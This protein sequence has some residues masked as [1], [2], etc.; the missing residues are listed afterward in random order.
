MG[1]IVRQGTCLLATFI[2]LWC[3]VL[4][5]KGLK[6]YKKLIMMGSARV[7]IYFLFFCSWYDGRKIISR[8]ECFFHVHKAPHKK[9]WWLSSR[10]FDKNWVI[11]IPISMRFIDFTIHHIDLLQLAKQT[12]GHSFLSRRNFENFSPDPEL[13]FKYKRD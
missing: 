11:S 4:L 1:A 6:N 3:L 7:N 10:N 13:T 2:L 5:G 9:Q 8:H 12:L